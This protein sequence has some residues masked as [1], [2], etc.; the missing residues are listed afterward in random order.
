MPPPYCEEHRRCF[1]RNSQGGL[2]CPE[3]DAEIE[4]ELIDDSLTDLEDLEDS[5]GSTRTR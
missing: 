2:T 1:T 3:C 5:N 4:D